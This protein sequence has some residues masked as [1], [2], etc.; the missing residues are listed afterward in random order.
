MHVRA[1]CE[2]F[3]LQSANLL[4]SAVWLVGAISE[5]TA[6]GGTLAF[7]SP[8]SLS[9]IPREQLSDATT[10]AVCVSPGLEGPEEAPKSADTQ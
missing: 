3:Q 5:A 2:E 1:R 6:S 9:N 10:G 4:R 7:L 8:P